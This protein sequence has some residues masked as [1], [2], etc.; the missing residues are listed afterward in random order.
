MIKVE[1]KSDFTYLFQPY[2]HNL[3]VIYSSLEGQYNGELYVNS[4][5]SPQIAVL[6][7]PFGFHYVAGNS[8]FPQA[9]SYIEQ[10]LFEEYLPNT[11]Q[12]EAIV[13][14]PDKDWNARLDDV[15]KNHR[16]IKDGRNIFQLNKDRFR[17]ILKNHSSVQN[18]ER[19]IVYERENGANIA[20]PVCR[21]YI[22]NQCVSFCSAFMLGKGHAEIDVYT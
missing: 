20:Y 5:D 14:S 13:F 19:K 17:E 4:E 3:P 21:I 6:F 12:Q 9:V 7:T 22:E 18:I 10:L 15:F 1:N 11:E 8:D 2:T 16:G